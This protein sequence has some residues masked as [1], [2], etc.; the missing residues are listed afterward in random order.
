MRHL[1]GPVCMA[2]SLLT[3]AHAD[4]SADLFVRLDRAAAA[5]TLYAPT[6]KPWHLKVDFTLNDENGKNPQQG[7]LE[8]W[9]GGPDQD[10]V[11]YT[12]PGFTGTV[13]KTPG[14]S[15]STPGSGSLPFALETLHNALVE[16]LAAELHPELKVAAL[17]K[18]S[19][20]KGTL[21]CITVVPKTVPITAHG[22]RGLYPIF[23]FNT[24][25]DE[26]RF[27]TPVRQ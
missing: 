8:E 14:G 15:F 4:N 20:G 6:L 2:L 19:F 7:T 25:S 16:P 13:L 21:D 1:F 26:L 24:D 27:A 9:W 11:T 10:R 22:P 3:A 12:S 17:E 5:T 18:T 23:C